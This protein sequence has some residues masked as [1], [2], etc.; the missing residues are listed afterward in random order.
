MRIQSRHHPFVLKLAPS[1]SQSELKFSYGYF[2]HSDKVVVVVELF[3]R[4]EVSVKLAA[5]EM[6]AR[7]S[8]KSRAKVW[9][10]DTAEREHL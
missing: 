5:L 1:F 7:L 8:V 2:F 10:I 6:C 9:D 3:D 4:W